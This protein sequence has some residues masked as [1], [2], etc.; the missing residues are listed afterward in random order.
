[1]FHNIYHI[2]HEINIMDKLGSAKTITSDQPQGTPTT[3]SPLGDLTTNPSDLHYVQVW[4][5]QIW[6]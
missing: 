1:M 6:N 5:Y 4:P 2:Y 3:E